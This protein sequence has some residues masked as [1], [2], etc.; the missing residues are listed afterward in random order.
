[1][2]SHPNSGFATGLPQ[3]VLSEM[4]GGWLLCLG[5][6]LGHSLFLPT[7]MLTSASVHLYSKEHHSQPVLA[8]NQAN[9]MQVDHC[10]NPSLVYSGSQHNSAFLLWE[11]KNSSYHW[12]SFHSIAGAVPTSLCCTLLLQDRLKALCLITQIYFWSPGESCQWFYLKMCPWQPALSCSHGGSGSWALRLSNIKPKGRLITLEWVHVYPST[13]T[14]E[15]FSGQLCS[16]SEDLGDFSGK[17]T[18]KLLCLRNPPPTGDTI[19]EE[20][21]I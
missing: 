19:W 17:Y 21:G 5:P 12:V 11:M 1:M 13:C 14:M 20:C 3:I 16:P 8:G 10:M 18:H 2:A 9:I 4:S 6:K 15:P 7:W